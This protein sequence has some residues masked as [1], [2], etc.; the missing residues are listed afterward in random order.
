MLLLTN[1]YIELIQAFFSIHLLEIAISHI[2]LELIN[3][4]ISKNL[5]VNQ[6]NLSTFISRKHATLR[7]L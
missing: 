1:E 7:F 5:L 6:S 3:I 4:F 2:H